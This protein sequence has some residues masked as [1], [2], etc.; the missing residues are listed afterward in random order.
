MGEPNMKGLTTDRAR[1]RLR[2]VGPNEAATA[3][4]TTA[5]YELARSF[6][7]PLVAVL[8]VA[9]IVS[10]TVGEW[11]N[12]TIIAAMVVLG[13]T[14]NFLQTDHSRRAVER[15]RKSV[16]P[17]ATV[18]RDGV[19][20]EVPRAEVVPGDWIRLV[21]GDMVPADARVI[22]CEHLHVQ[23]SGLTGESVPVEKKLDDLVYLGTSVVSGSAT[24]VVTATGPATSLGAIADRF[25]TRRPDTEFDRGTYQFGLFIMR[26]VVF[27][28]LF[29]FPINA[30]LK[31][32]PLESLLFAIALAVGLTPEFLPM[33]SSV[34]LAQGAVHMSREKVIVKNLASMQN[35]GSIDVLCSDKTGTLTSGHLDLDR[36]VDPFGAPSET[37]FRYAYINSTLQA[38]IQNPVDESLRTTGANPL[39]LAILSHDHPDIHTYQK[40]AEIPFDFERRLLS[41]VAQN[42]DQRVLITKGAPESVLSRCTKFEA[43]GLQEPID[44][45]SRSGCEKTYQAFSSQGL[46]VLGVA[47][48]QVPVQAKY[49]T[50]DELC[51]TASTTARLQYMACRRMPCPPAAA[52]FWNSTSRKRACFPSWIMTSWRICHRDS[53][54]LSQPATFRPQLI[55]G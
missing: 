21:P 36:H 44:A 2:E 24:A 23:E 8:P 22:E 35:F 30:A 48:R 14:I 41:I 6:A 38:G 34:T 12:A 37:T 49:E 39:D 51:L 29:V 9:S 33:I 55:D 40:A 16:A 47:Y 11:V 13:V 31:R 45:A 26:T 46:R 7:N 53:R 18:M 54:W 1:A 42:A 52:R 32:D 5:F 25:A 15:L 20:S 19:W 3:R 50:G 10:A 27:L 28:V 17:T 4:H 43:N